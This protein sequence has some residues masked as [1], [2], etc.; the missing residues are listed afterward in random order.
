MCLQPH[1]QT[2]QVMVCM[3]MVCHRML[4]LQGQCVRT[5]HCWLQHTSS[6]AAAGTSTWALKCACAVYPRS[7]YVKISCLC[8][9]H[10]S[11][12]CWQ[13]CLKQVKQANRLAFCLYV[14]LLAPPCLPVPA[15]L[16][17]AAVVMATLYDSYHQC[18]LTS[19]YH[20]SSAENRQ[21]S[22]HWC[23]L[24]GCVNKLTCT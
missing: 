24:C 16:P 7:E 8:E 18:V 9:R 22:R 11:P 3:K 17:A 5:R 13:I 1:V 4:G 12:A 14:F 23:S 21:A 15:C 20:H 10:I 2:C 6:T 19:F